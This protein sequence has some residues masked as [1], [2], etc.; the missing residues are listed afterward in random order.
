MASSAEQINNTSSSQIYTAACASHLNAAIPPLCCRCR[1]GGGRRCRIRS[2]PLP[3]AA[4]PRVDAESH[5]PRRPHPRAAPEA[6]RR[7]IHLP[8]S[9]GAGSASLEHRCRMRKPPSLL[10]AVVA[11]GKE[12]EAPDPLPAAPFPALLMLRAGAAA[13][14]PVRV[15]DKAYPLSCDLWNIPIRYTFAYTVGSR[16]CC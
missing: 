9:V 14:A 16:I 5:R 4:E 15:T 11:R 6:W 3:R 10:Y 12:E 13:A 8:R 7:W 2:R 1:W